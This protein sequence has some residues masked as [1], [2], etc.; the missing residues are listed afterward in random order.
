MTIDD[1]LFCLMDA[2][3]DYEQTD[4][5][6]ENVFLPND[7]EANL[8]VRKLHEQY[9]KKIAAI[10]EVVSLLLLIRSSDE[11]TLN[12]DPDGVFYE[13]VGRYGAR[14]GTIMKEDKE[15]G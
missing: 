3:D 9:T 4:N 8:Y 14:L 1:I 6:A 11:L 7:L 12:A 2:I 13:A 15:D 5:Q 10:K